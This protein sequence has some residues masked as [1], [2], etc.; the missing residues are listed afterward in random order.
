MAFTQTRIE[1]FGV[2][3]FF[4]HSEFSIPPKF[5][6]GE[7]YI[8]RVEVEYEDK[9]VADYEPNIIE[10]VSINGEPSLAT[11]T[12]A[13]YSGVVM[14]SPKKPGYRPRV[15]VKAE[16]VKNVPYGGIIPLVFNMEGVS[17]PQRISLHGYVDFKD[18]KMKVGGLH[19]DV[20]AKDSPMVHRFSF[21]QRG[22][23]SQLIVYFRIPKFINNQ[24]VEAF[25]IDSIYLQDENMA[26]L[27]DPSPIA[28]GMDVDNP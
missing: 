2:N 12:Y 11:L 14:E 26:E 16:G 28:I 27:F 15:M 17:R 8:S 10:N 25:Y 3:Q 9:K 4:L 21:E 19:V 22:N 18:S 24:K 20:L 6:K 5:Q 23:V 13:G 7:Y 1:P